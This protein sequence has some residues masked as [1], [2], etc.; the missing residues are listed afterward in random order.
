[1]AKNIYYHYN[2]DT[3]NFERVYPTFKS[4]LY[5]GLRYLCVGIII[6]ILLLLL[7][8]YGFSNHTEKSLMRENARLTTNYQLLKKRLDNSVKVISDLQ[9]RD[10]NFYRVMLGMEPV[11]SSRRLAGLDKEKRDKELD[12]LSDQELVENLTK[13]MDYLERQIYAQIHSYD[14]LQEKMDEQRDKMAHIPAIVPLETGEY[15]VACG[16]GTRHDPAN[17]MNRYHNGLDLTSSPGTPVTATASGKVVYAGQTDTKGYCVRIDHGYNYVTEYHHLG[18]LQVKE[19]DKVARGTRIGNVGISGKGM[20]PFLHYEVHF[21][22]V[23]VD[24]T[25][26][27]F[28]NMTPLQQEALADAAENAGRMLD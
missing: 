18:K 16:Y 2:A 11:S 4:R 24:P 14:E 5:S 25:D 1:M 28:L 3:D 17:G 9:R 8:Y 10:D 21:K 15:E 22:S 23:P 12:K 20:E 19:G 13:N 6:G 7:V 26:Y 27:C